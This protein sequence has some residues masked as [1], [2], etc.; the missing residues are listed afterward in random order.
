VPVLLPY[1]LI[2]IGLGDFYTDSPK[3]GR[4]NSKR[5]GAKP[6]IVGRYSFYASTHH[7]FLYRATN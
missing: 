3:I 6:V 7:P 4:I 2:A 5:K 1:A